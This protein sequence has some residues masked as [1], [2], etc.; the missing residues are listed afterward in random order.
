[1]TATTADAAPVVQLRRKLVED[2]SA[3]GDLPPRW[4]PAFE[5]VGRHLFVPE[6]VWR[7]DAQGRR[8][9]PIHRGEQPAAWWELVYRNEAVITQVN[10]GTVPTVSDG[11]LLG[12]APTSSAS[13]PTVV[14][15]MLAALNVEPGMDVLEIGTGTG[16]NTALLAHQLGAE[17]VTSVEIDP[18]LAAAAR[19][20]LAGAGY[21]AAEVLTGDGT[22]GYPPK[23]LYDRVLST[24]AVYQVPHAWIAQTR[25]GGVVVTPWATE[26]HNGHLLALTV[27]NN[28]TA[29]GTLLG[30]L[31][32]MPVRGQRI[33]RI[34]VDDVVTNTSQD[35]AGERLSKRHPR[36]YV[37]DYDTRAAIGLQVPR[38]KPRYTP[39]TPDE[40]TPEG[41]L[42]LL[43]QWSG[44]WAAI[45][46]R[47][48][49]PGPYRVRH[50]GP[51][52]LFT[53]VS[54]AYQRWKT[55][56]KPPAS[57]WRITLT[58]NGH[59]AELWNNP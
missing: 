38:C 5:T 47:P 9:E 27:H 1:V 23:A 59:H 36:W 51:R 12:A 41:I 40:G 52:D 30:P 25:P 19:S 18:Q 29:T 16:W 10:D 3:A 26:Y 37:A 56:G 22:S 46:H 55:A 44:S 43:D 8:L 7:S 28:G 11:V 34:Q 24:A 32:F 4:R 45:H 14:V 35:Q 15:R 20:A 39:P 48:D 50:Y 13:M 21:G 33:R 58:P 57:T 42:W 31:S 2:L 53:E 49:T 6:C 54:T 17:H